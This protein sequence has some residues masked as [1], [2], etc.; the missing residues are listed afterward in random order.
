MLCFAGRLVETLDFGGSGLQGLLTL[1]DT[2]EPVRGFHS[3]FDAVTDPDTTC[4][5]H[6]LIPLGTLPPLSVL[7]VVQ[8]N[9]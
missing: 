7:V 8:K 6:D 4:H 1:A 5:P 3:Q 9:N 2:N